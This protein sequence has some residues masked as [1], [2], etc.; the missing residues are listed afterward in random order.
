MKKFST[1][2]RSLLTTRDESRRMHIIKLYL[3]ELEPADRLQVIRILSGIKTPSLLTLKKLMLW[4]M[5]YKAIP[6][7]MMR[8]C[9]ATVGDWLETLGL[10]IANPDPGKVNEHSLKQVFTEIEAVRQH[11]DEGELKSWLLDAWSYLSSDELYVLHKFLTASLKPIIKKAA[12]AQVLSAMHTTDSSLLLH[13]LNQLSSAPIEYDQLIRNVWSPGELKTKPY[14]FIIPE[15]IQYEHVHFGNKEEWIVEEFVHGDRIQVLY[16][17]QDFQVHHII[18]EESFKLNES[19][20]HAL[21]KLPEDSVVELLIARHDPPLVYILD[22][23]RWGSLE[24]VKTGNI[25][26]RKNI[27]AAWLDLHQITSITLID[28]NPIELWSQH[29]ETAN[30]N[31]MLKHVYDHHRWHQIRAKAH[32]AITAL[33]YVEY[34]NQNVAIQYNMTLGVLNAEKELIPI[35]KIS[36]DLL[37]DADKNALHYWIQNNTVQK[38]GP[39]RVVRTSKG[40][41]ISYQRIEKNNR[42]KSGISLVHVGVIDVI[43]QGVKNTEITSLDQLTKNV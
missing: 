34:I 43:T 30:G 31:W 6:E 28:F 25:I 20:K 33:L 35:A 40:I 10:I 1:I 4:C 39:V 7:W 2:Y 19:L 24:Q 29:K 14:D 38:F 26:D 22:F 15:I 12:L 8:T 18:P 11:K 36:C 3:N 27:L 23:H 37:S 9:H 13:R 5:E 21:L 42:V 16:Q 41:H 32:E 17:N